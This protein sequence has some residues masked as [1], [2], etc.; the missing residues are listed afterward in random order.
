[1]KKLGAR[2][3]IFYVFCAIQSLRQI[4][5]NEVLQDNSRDAALIVV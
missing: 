3:N 5:L 4:R 2:N 1:M